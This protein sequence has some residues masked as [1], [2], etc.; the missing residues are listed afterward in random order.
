M[1]DTGR[2][3]LV[4]EVRGAHGD[5]RRTRADMDHSETYGSRADNCPGDRDRHRADDKPPRPVAHRSRGSAM[6]MTLPAR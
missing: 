2:R 4:E 3:G 5:R 1:I 6:L